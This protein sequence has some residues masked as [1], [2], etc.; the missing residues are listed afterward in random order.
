MEHQDESLRYYHLKT[1]A[2]GKQTRKLIWRIFWI[3]LAVTSVEI[4]LG[5]F[6]KDWELSW[7]FVKTTFL[8]LTVAKA[9]LIVSYYMHLKYEKSFLIK[10]IIIP[11]VALGLYLVA[12]I[13]NEGNYS[14]I[15]HNWLW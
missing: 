6:Y 5:L 10:I 12:L 11:Y 8:L 13:L 4:I 7:G 15:M 2:E 3:L 14:I 1:E 9:Y